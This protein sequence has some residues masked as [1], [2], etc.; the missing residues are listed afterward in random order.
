MLTILSILF[1]TP[2]TARRANVNDLSSVSGETN[3]EYDTA[4]IQHSAQLPLSSKSNG[5]SFR[6]R[7]SFVF[8]GDGRRACQCRA[9]CP[10][11]SNFIS[12]HPRDKMMRAYEKHANKHT[13][14]DL[15][16]RDF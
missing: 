9:A 16:T 13:N 14:L 3:G 7:T 1:I 4:S 12:W 10:A 15:A 2:T 8:H 6:L 5:F 11:A